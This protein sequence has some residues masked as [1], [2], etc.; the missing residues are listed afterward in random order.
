M[1]QNKIPIQEGRLKGGLK[2]LKQVYAINYMPEEDEY[3]DKIEIAILMEKK[4]ITKGAYRSL[5]FNN[6]VELLGFA[7]GVGKAYIYFMKQ[8]KQ[9]VKANYLYKVNKFI[10][11]MVKAIRLE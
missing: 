4:G 10:D 5:R 6:P 9:I 2:D 3:C 11:S 1:K 8:R 7:T